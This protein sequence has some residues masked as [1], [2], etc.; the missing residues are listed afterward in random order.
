[1]ILTIKSEHA[2][3]LSRRSKD[4]IQRSAWKANSAKSVCRILDNP[5]PVGPQTPDSPALR[6]QS[7]LPTYRGAP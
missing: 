2:T 5:G 6:A 1:M 7:P 3:T 4:P